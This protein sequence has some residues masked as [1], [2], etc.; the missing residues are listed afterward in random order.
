M[1]ARSSKQVPSYTAVILAC[2]KLLTHL[3]VSKGAK[4]GESFV[5]YVDFLAQKNYIPPD[6]REWVDHIR[7]KQGNEANHE[8]A[9]MSKDGAEE[10]VTFTEMLLKKLIYGFPAV[11]KKRFGPPAGAT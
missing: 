8:I 4:P 1:E 2:R 5:S 11:I 9:I 6:A 3:A 10:L 7:R